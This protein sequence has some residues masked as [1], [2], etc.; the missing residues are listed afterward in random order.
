[1]SFFL[2]Y[3]F[4]NSKGLANGFFFG[5][6]G[7]GAPSYD[8]KMFLKVVFDKT[9]ILNLRL[10][11]TLYETLMK[12]VQITKNPY[13]NPHQPMNFKNFSKKI[14]EPKV[15]HVCDLQKANHILRYGFKNL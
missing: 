10:V 8:T 13:K 11:I 5:G 4:L 3:R 2:G 1:M 14:R 7:G 12:H 6:V 15:S 9:A